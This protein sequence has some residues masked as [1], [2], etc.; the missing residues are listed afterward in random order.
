MCEFMPKNGNEVKTKRKRDAYILPFYFVSNKRVNTRQEKRMISMLS[1]DL[2]FVK[3]LLI[4]RTSDD[5]YYNDI[6]YPV[7]IPK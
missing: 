7:L 4:Y 5:I 2:L 6:N 3:I 1:V